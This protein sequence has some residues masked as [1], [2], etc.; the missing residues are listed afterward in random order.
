MSKFFSSVIKKITVYSLLFALIWSESAGG[1]TSLAAENPS[2][3]YDL[4]DAVHISTVQ[5]LLS[6]SKNCSLDTWSQNKIFVL[7]NDIDLT[8]A[9]FEPIPGL[10]RRIQ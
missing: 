5:D 10:Y 7:D 1:F 2:A 8:D 9:A 3:E 4:T 6:F